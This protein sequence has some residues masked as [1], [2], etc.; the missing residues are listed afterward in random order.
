MGRGGEGRGCG[1]GTLKLLQNGTWRRMRRGGEVGGGKKNNIFLISLY[2]CGPF[3]PSIISLLS[4]LCGDSDLAVL[5][6][7]PFENSHKS[8][9]AFREGGGS[10]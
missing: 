4:C 6:T 8:Q 5:L 10:I 1:V 2:K 9:I 7:L 3:P